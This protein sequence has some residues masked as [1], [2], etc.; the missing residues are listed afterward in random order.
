M[1]ACSAPFTLKSGSIELKYRLK[2]LSQLRYN[3]VEL[4]AGYNGGHAVTS[5]VV[6]VRSIALSIDYDGIALLLADLCQLSASVSM[7][8]KARGTE[9]VSIARSPQSPLLGLK[10]PRAI[11]KEGQA[12]SQRRMQPGLCIAL[13][14]ADHCDVQRRGDSQVQ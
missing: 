11:R 3:V 12:I 1:A 14:P 5:D 2:A 8:K 10:H 7:H 4:W 9:L 13:P 6:I